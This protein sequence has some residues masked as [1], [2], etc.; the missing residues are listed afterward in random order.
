MT[1]PLFLC[2]HIVDRLRGSLVGWLFYV[3][4]FGFLIFFCL[5]CFWGFS[6]WLVLSV[7]LFFF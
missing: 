1:I 7:L 3:C 4:W 2:V 6:L 5:F